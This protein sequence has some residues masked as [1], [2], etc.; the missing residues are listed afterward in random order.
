MLDRIELLETSKL[1]SI[2]DRLEHLEVTKQKI[3]TDR[4]DAAEN[5]LDRLQNDSN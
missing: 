3:I 4:L 1:K 2:Q 5:K